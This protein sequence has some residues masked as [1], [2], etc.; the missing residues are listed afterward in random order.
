MKM[1]PQK[2]SNLTYSSNK[3]FKK[4]NC[5]AKKNIIVYKS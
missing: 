5:R 1:K 2:L 3:K 4:C